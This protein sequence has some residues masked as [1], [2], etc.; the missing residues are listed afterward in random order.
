MKEEFPKDY[1]ITIEGDSFREGRISVNK[2]NQEYVAEIDIV[3]IESRKIWQH[4]KT[5]YGRSTAR[6]ALEDGSYT[7]GKYLRGES[8]I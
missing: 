5:I 4:V 1:F 8:V 3:Q 2:L 7:L 6:D